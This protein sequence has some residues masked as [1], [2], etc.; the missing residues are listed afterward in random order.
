MAALSEE[1]FQR[2]QENLLELKTRNY[3]LEEQVRVMMV[4]VMIMVV[5]MVMVMVMVMVA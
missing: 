1:D 5:I 4:I 3:T 2:L